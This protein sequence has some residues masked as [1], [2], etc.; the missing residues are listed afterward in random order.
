MQMVDIV[1]TLE[2]K[3]TTDMSVAYMYIFVN[4]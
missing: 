4:Q 2:D 1:V 3:Y